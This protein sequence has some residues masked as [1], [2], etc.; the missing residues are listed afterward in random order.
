MVEIFK[1]RLQLKLP[2]FL[3]N[4]GINCAIVCACWS[5]KVTSSWTSLKSPCFWFFT[6]CY[7]SSAP[8]KSSSTRKGWK[9]S[10]DF[11]ASMDVL[12]RSRNQLY[13][14]F[15]FIQMACSLSHTLEFTKLPSRGAQ[16]FNTLQIWAVKLKRMHD[17]VWLTSHWLPAHMDGLESN[18][19]KRCHHKV[20]KDSK[21]PRFQLAQCCSVFPF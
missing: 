6:F 1:Y 13:C 16:M 7:L 3:S 9:C 2:S 18:I 4:V 19:H 17:Q 5:E 12:K 10:N 14:N 21:P 20:L 8:S 11:F 15:S